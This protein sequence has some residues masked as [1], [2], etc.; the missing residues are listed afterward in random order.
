MSALACH[1]QLSETLI[2]SLAF[3]QR[4]KPD[5]G[6][7]TYGG[8]KVPPLQNEDLIRAFLEAGHLYEM[9]TSAQ[10]TSETDSLLCFPRQPRHGV[11]QGDWIV[12]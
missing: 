5:C 11:I 2:K 12:S 6:R 4:L 8:T 3:P 1:H 10:V 7:W 9:P